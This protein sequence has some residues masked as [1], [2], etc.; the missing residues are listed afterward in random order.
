MKWK[1]LWDLGGRG[2]E[3]GIFMGLV[4]CG[5]REVVLICRVAALSVQYW[6]PNLNDFSF[7]PRAPSYAAGNSLPKRY[8]NIMSRI[9]HGSLRIRERVV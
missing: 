4:W 6:A 5:G 8:Q 2:D 9:D 3:D 1:G 7:R